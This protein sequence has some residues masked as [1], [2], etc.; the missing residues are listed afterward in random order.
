M[1]TQSPLR[2]LSKS[3]QTVLFLAAS[4]ASHHL[5]QATIVVTLQLAVLQHQE[6]E[7]AMF[8]GTDAKSYYSI[9]TTWYNTIEH[10]A[11]TRQ[12]DDTVMISAVMLEEQAYNA[13][14]T[15]QPVA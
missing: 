6:Q 10:D 2:L 4:L 1:V 8:T 14:K 9:N 5:I 12:F 7:T 11:E 3:T 15:A 13:M